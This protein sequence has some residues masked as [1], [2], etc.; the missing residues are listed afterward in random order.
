VNEEPVEEVQGIKVQGKTK[1]NKIE[2]D[3]DKMN[4]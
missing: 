3:G 2:K 1:N 4:E